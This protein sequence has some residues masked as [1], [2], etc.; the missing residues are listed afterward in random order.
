[1]YSSSNNIQV[2][3]IMIWARHIAHMVGRKEIKQMY[4]EANI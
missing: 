3:K 2:I 4:G 1:M